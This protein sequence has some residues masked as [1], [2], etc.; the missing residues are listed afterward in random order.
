MR[1]M[2]CTKKPAGADLPDPWVGSI[3]PAKA[4]PIFDYFFVRS[5][6]PG[7]N[8]F[9]T[10]QDSME[11]LAHSGTWTVYR[12]QPG[13]VGPAPAVPPGTPDPAP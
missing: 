2:P 4:V 5:P 9:G 3:Q 6:P 13:A 10:Y 1:H 12:K 8:L 11:V 7:L